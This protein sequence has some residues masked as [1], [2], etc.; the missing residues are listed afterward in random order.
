M[1]ELKNICKGY[2]I[3]NKRQEVLK[4][5]NICFRDSEF[6]SI[7]GASGSGKTTLLNIIGGMEKYDSGDLLINGVSTKN[8]LDRDFDVY[9]NKTI[10]FVFQSYNLIGH[11][12]VLANVELALTL[13]GV[14]RRFRKKKAREVLEKVG[15][16]D[17]VN[18]KPNQLSG[19][20]M[21]R[22]A[23]ARALVNDPDIILA[24]EPT[25]ALDSLTS[26]QIMDLLKEISKNKLVV[27][28]THNSLIAEKYSD[29]IVELKDGYIISDSDPFCSTLINK[30]IFKKKGKKMSLISSLG[31]SFGNLLTKK[32]RTILT[33]FAGSIGIIG[34]A[35][36]L[37]LSNG[38]NKYISDFEKKSLS[39]Y[40]ISLEKKTYDYSK[41]LSGYQYE[42]VNCGKNEICS[43]DDVSKKI[44]YINNNVVKS[45]NLKEFKKYIDSKDIDNYVSYIQYGY[46][47]DLQIY[48]LKDDNYKRVSL[49]DLNLFDKNFVNT[50]IYYELASDDVVNSKYEVLRGRLPKLYNEVVLIVDENNNISDSLLYSLDIKNRDKYDKS[51]KVYSYDELM[52]GKYKLI[53][54]TDY[55]R[56]ENGVYVDYSNNSDYM[57]SI[58]NNGVDISIVGI[59]RAKDEG[60]MSNVIGYNYKLINYLI[61]NIENKDIV[62]KQLNNK[63]IDVFTNDKFDN[64]SY[65]DNMKLLGFVDRNDP[66]YINIFPRNLSSKEK[67]VSFIDEY[68]SMQRKGKKDDLVITY[69]DLVKGIVSSVTSVVKIVSII[70]IGVVGISL[71]VSSIMISII[72]Y[73][74]V[75][76]RTREIGILRAIGAS[77]RDVSNVFISENIIEGL[78]AGTFGVLITVLLLVPINLIIEKYVSIKNIAVLSIDNIFILVSLSVVITMIA[79]IIPAKMASRK[80]PVNAL[81]SE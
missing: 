66:S 35:L 16:G 6:V 71:I 29:R 77:K 32:G 7:L 62:K 42:R 3:G 27:M 59:I 8:Y 14:S 64:N 17:H 20:Q 2:E 26:I 70:L 10:G 79:G 30:N 22:V 78:V 46:D 72:T 68:N 5:I 48:A 49:D 54:N 56:Y 41:I 52:E 39:S 9:R 1:L 11:Q 23:I 38:V 63:N 25:G 47:I 4:N 81:R 43:N 55:Y 37:A 36:I 18:K 24:D 58:L 73:I 75:L 51:K 21:Q 45:N 40:P 31:L 67:I 13:S 80:K 76:E 50:S 12:S 44:N 74:S 57:K 15:L 19:G 34:I 65:S 28:V 53:L 60:E 61:D 33:S 69:T